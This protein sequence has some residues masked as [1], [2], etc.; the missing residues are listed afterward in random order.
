MHDWLNGKMFIAS[1]GEMC[2]TSVKEHN[3]LGQHKPKTAL[4]PIPRKRK[5]NK[6]YR[7][8]LV[9]YA[10]RLKDFNRAGKH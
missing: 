7:N 1:M 10:Y 6:N 2:L 8:N 3:E 4:K 5:G 9:R